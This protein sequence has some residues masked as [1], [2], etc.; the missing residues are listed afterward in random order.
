MNNKK[1]CESKFDIIVIRNVRFFLNREHRISNMWNPNMDN[2][3][4]E[5]RVVVGRVRPTWAR[6]LPDARDEDERSDQEGVMPHSEPPSPTEQWEQ[7]AK[8]EDKYDV[9][10]KVSVLNKP[11]VFNSR[12]LL[13]FFFL[14]D[15]SWT[16]V[17]LLFFS[18][19]S[20]S[21]IPNCI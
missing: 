11:F 15:R 16:T 8:Q 7:Q 10:G 21:I 19:C 5:K 20:F 2:R 6:N 17:K 13:F 1:C 9:F 12:Y 3:Q 14:N 4:M 18:F